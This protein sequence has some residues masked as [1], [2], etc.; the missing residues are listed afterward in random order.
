MQ[1][2]ILVLVSMPL[3]SASDKEVKVAQES[4]KALIRPLLPGQAKARPKGTE[5]FSVDKCPEQKVNWSDVLMMKET[6]TLKYRFSPGCDI[7]GDIAP[8]IL[9]PF[10][11]ILKLRNLGDYTKAESQNKITASLEAKPI[12][13]LEMTEGVLTGKK[14]TV[15][16]EADYRVRINPLK[17]DKIIDENLGGEIRIVEIFGKKVSIKEKIKVQ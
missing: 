12:A 16:F 3:W 8:R 7:E 6:V 11:A 10:P 15:K 14:G 13:L 2:L 17:Q 9:Q 1:I 5:K 4:I